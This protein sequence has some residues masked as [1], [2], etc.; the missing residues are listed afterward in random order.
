MKHNIVYII[1]LIIPGSGHLL[2]KQWKIGVT[3]VMILL[4]EIL[5]IIKFIVPTLQLAAFKQN[6]GRLTIGAEPFIHDSFIILIG[7]VLGVVLLA[8]FII[9]HLVYAINAQRIANEIALYGSI[10]TRW[11]NISG[12]VIPN[13]IITPKFL[14]IFGFILLPAVVSII[15]AF[16]N[17]RT[18]ILP[19]AFLIEWR[20]FEN[21]AKLATDPRMSALFYETLSWTVV[22]TFSS[23]LLV[24]SL[25][26]LLAVMVNNKYIKG[27]QLFR[28]IFILPWAVPAFLTILIFQYFFSRLGAMNSIIIPWLTGQPYSLDNTIPFL[29]NPELAKITII[30]IQGWLGFPYIFILV[31]GILQTIPSNLYEASSI[32]GGNAFSNFF[33]ITLPLILIS[34]SPVFITQVAFNF[35]NVVIIYLL[36]GAV[37]TPVGSMYSPLETIPSLG[38]RLMLDSRFNE[39]AVFSLIVTSVVGIAIVFS[40]IK[41]GAFKNEE[42]M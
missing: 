25:G 9:I 40:W 24:I 18:P 13:L 28:T 23:S 14:L 15:V 30:L 36:S 34:A 39:A 42:V 7:A 11:N 4:A 41:S 33:H 17:Y 8:L 12:E 6:D 35:N 16:T 38:F 20:G 19:P 21:F 29:I 3:G 27:K 22:W 37:V 5:T 26:I 10:T 2:L 1:S 32:D 31:T